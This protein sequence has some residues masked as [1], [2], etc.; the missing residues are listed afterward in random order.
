M[1]SKNPL[2]AVGL[3]DG[4]FR[5]FDFHRLGKSKVPKSLRG[6]TMNYTYRLLHRFPLSSGSE[7]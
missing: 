7:K 3:W 5:I 1:F 6:E 2:T 4:G